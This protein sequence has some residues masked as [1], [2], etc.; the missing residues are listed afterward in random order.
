MCQ[1]YSG[2]LVTYIRTVL[3]VSRLGV[4]VGRQSGLQV[5]PATMFSLLEQV[6]QLQAGLQELPTRYLSHTSLA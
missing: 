5:I 2:T 6:M 4:G 1:Y 3:Q